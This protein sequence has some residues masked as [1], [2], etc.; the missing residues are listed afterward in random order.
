L[1]KAGL[2]IGA[3]AR[4]Q[5]KWLRFRADLRDHDDRTGRIEQVVSGAGLV[6][7]VSDGVGERKAARARY[8]GDV[9]ARSG[10]RQLI[11][12]LAIAFIVEHKNREIAG[13]ARRDR[14]K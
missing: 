4:R 10:V 8:A 9:C 2:Q 14:R 7:R 3:I 1:A 11:A 6:L 5:D 12:G 13:A